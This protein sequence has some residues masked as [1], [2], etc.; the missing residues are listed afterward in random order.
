MPA[1]WLDDTVE[2]VRETL[3][4][5]ELLEDVVHYHGGSTL[6][7]ETGRPTSYD[8]R[9]LKA[10]I[11]GNEAARAASDTIEPGSVWTLTFYDPVEVGL[12]DY[13]EWG[14]SGE[15]HAVVSI[16]GRVRDPSDNSRYITRVGVN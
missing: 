6:D 12:T 4:D 8:S 7:E 2:A 16:A 9:K 13:F 1:D 15:R 11:V 10:E 5:L 3:D 14:S